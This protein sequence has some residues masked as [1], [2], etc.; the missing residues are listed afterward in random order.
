MSFLTFPTYFLNL[1]HFFQFEFELLV[2]I[3]SEKPPGIGRNRI[4]FQKLFWPFTAQINFSKDQIK[5]KSRLALRRFFQKTNGRIWFVCHE[6][7][8]SK[9]N[10]FVHSFVRFLG[11]SMVCKSAFEINLPLVISKCFSMTT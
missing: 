8:L 5:P 10:K 3:R 2:F 6:E 9:Q 1:Y 4:L 7:L 11:E